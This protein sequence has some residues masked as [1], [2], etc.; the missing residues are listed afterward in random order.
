[1]SPTVWKVL[2]LFV[3][4]ALAPLAVPYVLSNQ[5]DDAEAAAE[6]RDVFVPATG[7]PVVFEGRLLTARRLP[8]ALVAPLARR[9]LAEDL[10]GYAATLPETAC[11]EVGLDGVSVEEV[12]SDLPLIPASTMKLLTA[13]T[14]LDLA[15][16]SD[17]FVTQVDVVAAPVDGVVQGDLHLVGGGDPLLATAEYAA[18]FNRQPQP[19]TPLED[20]AD[21]I[22]AAGVTRVTGRV[23][24]DESRYDTVRLVATWP[25]RYLSQNNAGPLSAL[26]VN[27]GYDAFDPLERADNP[28]AWAAQALTA[29]LV[30]RGVVVDG[31]PASGP[32]AG[33]TVPLAS[34]ESAP[35]SEIVAQMLTLSDN[36]TAE[37]LEKEIGLRAEGQ[38]STAAGAAAAVA[39]L[40]ELGFDT[41]GLVA[42]DG[43][44]LDRGDRVTCDLLYEI[45]DREGGPGTAI[46]AG[47]AVAG[48]SGTLEG[49]F[50]D[51]AAAGR[52]RAKTGFLNGVNAL[53]GYV[54]AAEGASV[55]TFSLIV[56]DV[57][58]DSSLGLDLQE[59][60]AELLALHP[61]TPDLASLEP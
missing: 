50:G 55:V 6:A 29:E 54:Q 38:G 1:V 18:S 43:S 56:N 2:P 39:T 26:S 52:L 33:A 25:D 16:E 19:R 40:T 41:T 53:A 51:S 13:T 31:A 4:L 44:G 37:M 42:I 30:E 28:A 17:T 27:D 10:A 21:A 20:L 32:A 57:P 24:G 60:L 45:I 59:Q 34:V 36:N 11:L 5:A 23:L 22:V 46:G 49:R 58:L 3:V 9:R 48:E 7:E 8:E 14:I 12:R 47:L 35:L 61:Q 15:S